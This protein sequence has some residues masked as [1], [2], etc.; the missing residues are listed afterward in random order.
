MRSLLMCAAAAAALAGIAT[1][2]YFNKAS[3]TLLPERVRIK[4][5]GLFGSR[6]IDESESFALDDPD[7]LHIPV[8]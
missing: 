2:A 1:P 8:R 6:H 7:F 4:S 5:S 3:V